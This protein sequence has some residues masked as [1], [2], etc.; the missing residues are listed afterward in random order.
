M[1]PTLL[2]ALGVEWA[3][4]ILAI[5]VLAITAV[6]LFVGFAPFTGARMA[7]ASVAGVGALI[8]ILAGDW[9]WS[10]ALG[11]LAALLAGMALRAA[12]SRD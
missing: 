12:L 3:G 9:V 5:F 8:A 11:L 4:W 2:L 6:D 7:C 10:V 1:P